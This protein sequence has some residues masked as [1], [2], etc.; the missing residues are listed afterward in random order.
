MLEQELRT[1]PNGDLWVHYFRL[2]GASQ[3]TKDT[4]DDVDQ[5]LQTMLKRFRRTRSDEAY[6]KVSQLRAFQSALAELESALN[7]PQPRDTDF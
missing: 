5:W 3:Q 2:P 4:R 6:G 1:W 7:D